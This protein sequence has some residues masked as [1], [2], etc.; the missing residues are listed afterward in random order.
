MKSPQNI[1]GILAKSLPGQVSPVLSSIM[2]SHISNIMIVGAVYLFH[3]DR[4][5]LDRNIDGI[6]SF[7]SRSIDLCVFTTLDVSEFN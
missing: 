4:F 5:R 1:V 3:S 2:L 6:R 7:T